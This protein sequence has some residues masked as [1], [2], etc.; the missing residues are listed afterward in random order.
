MWTNESI[1]LR[2]SGGRKIFNRYYRW[3]EEDGFSVE[4]PAAAADRGTGLTVIV[5]G[6]GYTL[7]SPYLFY[8][9][10]VPYAHGD[11]VL[12]I[13]FEYGRNT[14]FLEA[15]ETERDGWFSEDLR[16]VADYLT[17]DRHR[18]LSFIGK[19]LGTSVVA[20]LLE[21]E[22]VRERTRRAVWLTPGK[23]R[24]EIEEI[25]RTGDFPN[26]FVYGV[27]D[28]YTAGTPLDE[29]R[30]IPNTRIVVVPGADHA[31]ETGDPVESIGRLAKYV[32]IL[33]EFYSAPPGAPARERP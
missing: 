7:E 20:G 24:C 30:K 13:D 10:H 2:G 25:A 32:E 26:L 15:N 27:D 9:K 5:A 31:L 12:A 17:A 8:S 21:N 14:A 11:E 3:A 22:A 19:S 4:V 29:L 18:E 6:F 1:E 33:D 16:G 28:P 23:K